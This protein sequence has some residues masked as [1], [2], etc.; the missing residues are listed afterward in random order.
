MIQTFCG[1]SMVRSVNYERI[2]KA[3]T[4]LYFAN[5]V[6]DYLFIAVCAGDDDEDNL[7]LATLDAAVE[8]GRP[9]TT[10]C[11]FR[12]TGVCSVAKF[13][14]TGDNNVVQPPL[15]YKPVPP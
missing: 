7:F 2:A 13:L 4:N 9:G 11:V 14:A 1:F 8:Q 10:L 15:P 5:V 6:E 12:A 3:P